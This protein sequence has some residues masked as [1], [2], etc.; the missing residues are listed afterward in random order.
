MEAFP[1]YP[2][3]LKSPDCKCL[4]LLHVDDI[5]VVCSQSFL[6]GHLLKALRTKDKVS[7]EAI[8]SVGDSITFLKRRIVLEDV[9]KLVIYPH[10]KHFDKL[11]ELMGVK[12]TW[13]PKHTP[14]HA[15]VLEVMQSPELG[16]QQSSAYRSA[17]GILLYL[18]CDMVQC[19]WMIRHLAQSMSKPTLKA[20]TELR[21]LVQYVL[22]C[23][24]YGLMMHY[25]SDFDGSDFLLKTYT[26]SDWA[27]NKGT[28]KSVSA[29]CLVMNGCLLNSG[30]RNQ[31]LVALS[32]AEAETYAATS[33][34][35][36][37]LFLSR[38]LGYLL[39][40]EISI[41]LL[42]DN[43]A[44]RYI[45]SRAGCG[46]VRHLST[47]VLWMQQR[48]ERKELSVG[49]V[50]S[51]ENVSDIGTKRVSVPTMKYLM[52]NLGVYDGETST[53]VG[54][55]EYD[56]RVSKQNLKLI[57][58]SSN[59]KV[60]AN[61]IRLIVASSLASADAL[62][63][64]TFS[65]MDINMA[66]IDWSFLDG[67]A[68]NLLKF[69]FM[70]LY[71]FIQ[72]LFMQLSYILEYVYG[73]FHGLVVTA[74]PFFVVVSTWVGGVYILVVMTCTLCRLVYG[75][76]AINSKAGRLFVLGVEWLNVFSPYHWSGM[77]EE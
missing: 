16:A 13:K 28:R 44:C 46:R 55:D 36:D 56:I 5:L 48:V 71:Y 61:L 24:G 45:L 75:K 40:A 21:H 31:G 58:T 54:Q 70:Q 41:N 68:V 4:M 8:R 74:M 73:H 7:A 27:S 62:S 17:V 77:D 76:D 29:C 49:A 72:L 32:S 64:G 25:Q 67:T 38:C 33:G 50:P 1:L 60:S 51:A 14:A 37:A 53:L 66:W 39:E 20:W 42:I 69:P 2:C 10:P 65:A 12:K 11:F 19:Q 23:T 3:L 63:C 43:S 26:D 18:S 35:C 6:D 15:Q 57:T 30:S 59:S 34:A 52:R 47:R 9:L 22:G